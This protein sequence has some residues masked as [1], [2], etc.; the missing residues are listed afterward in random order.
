[1][2]GSVTGSISIITNNGIVTSANK[3]TV[4]PT[5]YPGV[6]QGNKLVGSNA[7]GTSFQGRSVAI[8]ADGN[9][10]IVGGDRDNSNGAV[11]VYTR[12]GNTWT[13]QGNK[14]V[15]SGAIGNARQA[16]SI[17]LSADGNTA[18]VGG[19]LDNA[20]VGAAW[21]FTRSGGVW[22]QQG[23]KLFDPAT[24]G[25]IEDQG[26]SLSL[27]ADGN[28]AIVG[29][30]GDNF[31][32]GAAW[33][34]TRTNG[35][36]S[37]QTKLFDPTVAGI[38]GD[39]QGSS[40]S[41][42]ADG[43]TAVVGGFGDNSGKGAIWIYTRNGNTWTQQGNKLVGTGS[44]GVDDQGFATA[45]S[46]DGNTVIEGG[47]EY[48]TLI[49]A[50]WIFTRSGGVWTQQGN[51]L[52]G[53]GSI[54]GA[55]QG[56]AVSLSADGNTALIGG[57]SDNSNLGAAWIFT[58]NGNV[59]TQQGNKITGTGS[60]GNPYFGRSVALSADGSTSVIGGSND[61][62]NIGAAWIF[63]K[64]CANNNWVGSVS[65]AWENPA[66]WSC[67]VVP[68]PDADVTINSGTV[69]VNSNVTIRSLSLSP[70]VSFTVTAP[71]NLTTTH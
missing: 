37:L 29:G 20:E 27:S 13:Q 70:G 35:V 59:W 38:F 26:Y 28:T 43:N 40:V 67:G 6:Q 25:K 1:M 12:S 32:D 22:S 2:P 18:I 16:W 68:G 71:F 21:I 53:T 9:T 23:N 4:I 39:A 24:A 47:N 65:H 34:Y 11:W 48:D 10:A 55:S 15:G 54:G 3:F 5:E 46:A 42:S 8:S 14:L 30:I 44:T 41:L 56:C 51:K 31:G 50:A 17:A 62:S 57:Q 52:I 63:I 64:G 45:I 60:V 58:R 69:V 19:F 61:N 33:I 7:A 36:W 66:N 49:G